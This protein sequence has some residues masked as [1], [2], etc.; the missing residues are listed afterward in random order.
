M[1]RSEQISA[2]RT[3]IPTDA[4]RSPLPLEQFQNSSLRPIL[5]FQNDLFLA[6]FKS[7]LNGAEIP[8]FKM[9]IEQFVKLRLQKDMTIR[10]TLIGMVL[11]LLTEGELQY[12]IEHKNEMN[13]RIVD[14]LSQRI[15]EQL[16]KK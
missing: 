7:Q 10:N 4:E 6:Y 8:D 1:N 5:K 12:F 9:E 2:L 13:K 16:G 14:M 3:E 15:A 11:A